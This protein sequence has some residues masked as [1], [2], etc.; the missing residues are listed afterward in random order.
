MSCLSYFSLSRPCRGPFLLLSMVQTLHLSAS[1]YGRAREQLEISLPFQFLWEIIHVTSCSVH[2]SSHARAD[3]W[4]LQYVVH[5]HG[6]T[7]REMQRTRACPPARLRVRR[8]ADRSIHASEAVVHAPST[9]TYEPSRWPVGLAQGGHVARAAG[10]SIA[11]HRI[12]PLSPLMARAP[13][14]RPHD[15]RTAYIAVGCRCSITTRRHRTMRVSCL[16]LAPPG[17]RHLGHPLCRR[18]ATRRN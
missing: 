7:P 3:V 9:P 1:C 4:A 14:V 12:R 13:V 11:S 10:R 16:R 18:A 8:C 15:R 5:I 2:A 6:S 17:A